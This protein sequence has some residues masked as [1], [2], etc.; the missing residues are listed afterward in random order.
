MC[1]SKNTNS[2]KVNDRSRNRRG[3]TPPLSDPML[4]Q[5]RAPKVKLTPTVACVH[6]SD[7]ASHI[8]SHSVSDIASDIASHSAS[9]VAC[10][11]FSCEWM[12]PRTEQLDLVYFP[13][14][15]PNTA[16]HGKGRPPSFHYRI[17]AT[18]SPY[19]SLCLMDKMTLKNQ[20]ICLGAGRR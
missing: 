15:L 7:I 5:K 14:S 19:Y 18:H 12:C 17:Y 6:T 20:L 3:V 16:I 8:A 1:I 2:T 9:D 13:V 11:P 10:A 4:L